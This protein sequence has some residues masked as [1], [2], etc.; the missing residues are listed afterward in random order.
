MKTSLEWWYDG[1]L[2]P[3]SSNMV[4]GILWLRQKVYNLNSQE[5]ILD[6]P[7]SAS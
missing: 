1:R 5:H 4:P 6:T 2:T 3:R 7:E